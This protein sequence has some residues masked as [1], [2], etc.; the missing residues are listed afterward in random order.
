MVRS[1][2]GRSISQKLVTLLIEISMLM[3]LLALVA[4][5]YL[6]DAFQFITA[7]FDYLP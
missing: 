2:R 5:Q 6:K 1:S 4:P 3:A 7:L